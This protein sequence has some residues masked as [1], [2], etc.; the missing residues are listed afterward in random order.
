MDYYEE[1][2]SI[3]P[4]AQIPTMLLYDKNISPSVKLFYCTITSLCSQDGYCWAGDAYLAELYDV[5]TKSVS[6]W[7]E[8]LEAND[9]I[10]IKK[11]ECD[12]NGHHYKSKRLIFLKYDPAKKWTKMSKKNGQKCPKKMDKNVHHNNINNNIN[13]IYSARAR[14]TQPKE[15]VKPKNSFLDFDQRQYSAEDNERI[16][17]AMLGNNTG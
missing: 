5:S 10:T 9:Y 15:K 8:Q 16:F 12:I 11:A 6:R 17:N 1:E 7:L 3:A 4:Y 14:V 2:H 13:N